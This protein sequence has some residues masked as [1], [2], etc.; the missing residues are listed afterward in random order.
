MQQIKSKLTASAYSLGGVN[1]PKLFLFYDHDGTG[2]I[3]VDEF[4]NLLRKD[5]KVTSR[6]LSDEML[7]HLFAAIDQDNSGKVAYREFLDWLQLDDELALDAQFHRP[8]DSSPSRSLHPVGA[9]HAAAAATAY[10]KACA[11]MVVPSPSHGGS[12][13]PKGLHPT[14]GEHAAALATAY[15]KEVADANPASSS[16]SEIDASGNSPN[17]LRATPTSASRGGSL[18]AATDAFGMPHEADT[19]RKSPEA[20]S[21]P[22]DDQELAAILIQRKVRGRLERQPTKV[23]NAMPEEEEQTAADAA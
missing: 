23:R 22:S 11:E 10:R 14:G 1:W 3:N 4:A 13:S 16:R 15:R 7:K 12:Q 9:E 20:R 18:A 2:D 19:A 8:T 17:S 21:S 5:A 6:M